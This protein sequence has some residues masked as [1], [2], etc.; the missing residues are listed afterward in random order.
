VYIGKVEYINHAAPPV[1][2][3]NHFIYRALQKEK[4][5]F[6]CENELRALISRITLDRPETYNIRWNKLRNGLY[7][8][9]NVENFVEKVVVSP[10]PNTLLFKAVK[11]VAKTY[12][13]HTDFYKRVIKSSLDKNLL[14]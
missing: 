14:S 12:F 4:S 6:E 7:V 11:S 5:N 8:R 2:E 1:P 9:V 3:D 10:S 13:S